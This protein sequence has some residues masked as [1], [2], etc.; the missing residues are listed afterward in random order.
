MSVV[1]AKAITSL[2]ASTWTPQ[3]RRHAAPPVCRKSVRRG[4]LSAYGRSAERSP[5][6]VGGGSLRSQFRRPS[7]SVL[8]ASDPVVVA[9]EVVL[10]ERRDATIVHVIG[11]RVV[12]E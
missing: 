5:R 4:G 2:V 1:G 7:G 3:C 12:G 8:L 6:L 9:V 10:A 11:G